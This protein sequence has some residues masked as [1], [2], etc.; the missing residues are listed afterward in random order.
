MDP[1]WRRAAEPRPGVATAPG[2]RLARRRLCKHLLELPIHSGLF[3]TL[4]VGDW[5]SLEAFRSPADDSSY[6]F[7]KYGLRQPL[8][9]H[10]RR[11]KPLRWQIDDLAVRAKFVGALMLNGP[12]SLECRLAAM[13]AGHYPRA[14]PGFGVSDCRCGGHLFV[15]GD[16]PSIPGRRKPRCHR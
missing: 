16:G 8:A 9:R 14:V 15:V 11:S 7:L 3:A 5:A 12:K 4:E 10:A 6:A 2:R 1:R 13:L